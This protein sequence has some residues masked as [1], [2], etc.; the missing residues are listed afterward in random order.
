MKK[1]IC[2][3]LSITLILLT[4]CIEKN[5]EANSNNFNEGIRDYLIYNIETM[6]KDLIMLDE[7]SPRQEDLLISLFDGLVGVDK[8]NNI[9]PELAEKWEI[10][11]DGIDYKFHIKDNL[12]WSNGNK[13]VARDFEDFFKDIFIYSKENS[14]KFNE[15]NS[16]YG[17]KDYLINGNLDN[18][19]I[20]AKENNILEV[21]LNN[22]DSDFLKILSKPKYKLR[23]I[24]DETKNYKE[25]FNN[26][27][28]TGAFK[29]SKIDK[30]NITVNKN[31]K[32]WDKENI[33][34]NKVVFKS[35][36]NSEEALAYLRTDKLDL[37][38]NPPIV[39]LDNLNKEGFI[40]KKLSLETANIIFN[41]KDYIDLNLRRAL[42]A[43]INRQQICSDILYNKAVPAVA[44]VPNNL[45]ENDGVNYSKNY[46]SI[47]EN[48]KR[49][50]EFL[51]KS[52]YK[53]SNKDLKIISMEDPISNKII[54]N[55]IE[56]IKDNLDINIVLINCK[57]E[58]ELKQKMKNGDYD[59]AFIVNKSNKN[60]P[61]KFLYSYTGYSVQYRESLNKIESEDNMWKKREHINKAQD[62]LVKDLY[63]IPVCFF[64]DILCKKSRVQGQYI[65]MNGN[66]VIKKIT[67]VPYN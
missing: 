8:N 10:S 19:A 56:K 22:K 46:F 17:V 52:E 43:C 35:I 41:K 12:F 5:K 25:N 42:D 58:K 26:I 36:K 9:V 21:R 62:I 29:I 4:G 13:I 2:F 40:S 66:I 33:K 49:A 60:N 63:S 48:L 11:K 14:I 44:Y 27:Q 15:L 67:L 39:E 61:L 3:L 34:M 30:E 54:N 31:N 20:K 51:Q 57:N 38:M 24:D 6:P 16:I 50:K 65:D 7:T 23:K 37:F 64:Y 18:I 1:I 55:L 59:L 47:N 53:K 28:Y 45:E 32:Y